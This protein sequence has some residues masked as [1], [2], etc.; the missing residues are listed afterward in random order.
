MPLPAWSYL[1]EHAIVPL[2]IVYVDPTFEQPPLLVNRRA[3]DAFTSKREVAAKEPLEMRVAAIAGE[4]RRGE[5][6]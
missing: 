3:L 6:A 1:T 5:P 4:Q 2:V